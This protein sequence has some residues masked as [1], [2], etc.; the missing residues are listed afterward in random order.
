MRSCER[1]WG[2]SEMLSPNGDTARIDAHEC[3]LE[4]TGRGEGMHEEFECRVC[5]TVTTPAVG[6][7]R[8]KRQ[9]LW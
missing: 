4:P 6:V 7:R 1:G 3:E 9:R 5:G 2:S 8:A